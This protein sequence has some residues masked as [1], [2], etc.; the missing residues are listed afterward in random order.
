[1]ADKTPDASECETE[2]R[3][4]PGLDLSGDD[5]SCRERVFRSIGTRR[6]V[7]RLGSAA[8]QDAEARPVSG[9]ARKD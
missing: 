3:I 2:L 1:M 4:W 6:K 7:F 8:E 5:V 9:K